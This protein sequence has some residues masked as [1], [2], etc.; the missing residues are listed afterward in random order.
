MTIVEL[1]EQEAQRIFTSKD[2]KMPEY[3]NKPRNIKTPRMAS[4]D[5]LCKLA[6]RGEHGRTWYAHANEQIQSHAD[7]IGVN[8][9][10]VADILSIT[11][12]R[13]AVSRNI[14]LAN[15]FLKYGFPHA[16]TLPGTIAAL[17]HY[18]DT[19]EIRGPKTSAFAHALRGN[20]NAVVLDVWMADACKCDQ[21]AFATIGGY[22]KAA[23][24][25][26]SASRRLGWTPAETQAAIWCATV[27]KA[28]RKAPA[29]TISPDALP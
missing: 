2:W 3:V 22:Q 19:G 29:F 18:A 24:R 15:H 28:G 5:T 4:V 12:P 11:S 16:T 7:T 21:K 17:K 1:Y 20:S 26:V 14:K 6:E 9:G 25:V 13:V 27:E 8:A 10:I 23:K